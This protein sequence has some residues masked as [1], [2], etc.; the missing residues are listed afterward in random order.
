MSKYQHDMEDMMWEL[1]ADQRFSMPALEEKMKERFPGSYSLVQ[2][3]NTTQD[4]IPIRMV[5]NNL[6][7]K[8]EWMMRWD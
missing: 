4:Y 2:E 8:T 1:M 3:P 6:Y 5:F 7:E